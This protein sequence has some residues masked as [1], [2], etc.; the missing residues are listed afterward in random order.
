MCDVGAAGGAQIA[1]AWSEPTA[2][3]GAPEPGRVGSP[4][5]PAGPAR[6]GGPWWRVPGRRRG[7]GGV[8]RRRLAGASKPWPD[9]GWWPPAPS[10]PGRRSGPADLKS[11]PC[12]SPGRPPPGLPPAAARRRADA[13]RRLCPRRPGREPRCWSRSGQP[14][15]LRPVSMAVRP[16]SLAGCRR[17]SR[18]MSSPRWAAGA[19]EPSWSWLG[20]P[21]CWPSPSE[22][23]ALAT[24]RPV[25]SPSGSPPWLRWRRWCRR[26]MPGRSPWLQPSP[27]TV[28]APGP[29]PDRAVVSGERYVLLGL[30][31]ARAPWFEAWPSGRRLP[32]SRLSSSSACPRRRSGPAWRRAGGTPPCWSTPA[33]R[34]SIGTWSTPLGRWAPVIAVRDA[35]R[36]RPVG[37]PARELG[38]AAELP[39]DFGRDQLLDVLTRTAK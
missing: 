27:P 37:T 6:R 14:P 34:R 33:A 29:E 23:G 19:H 10:R 31:P 17:V 28:S 12:A 3:F 30:A 26:P 25:R 22:P 8:R 18:W 16:V 2:R 38:V 39:A 4:G 35:E 5:R 32:P 9:T 11:R 24:G 21:P 7:R 1:R 13:G 15:P 20:A 36:R